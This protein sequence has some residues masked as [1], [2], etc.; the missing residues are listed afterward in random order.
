M[1]CTAKQEAATSC[2]H[3]PVS[4]YPVTASTTYADGTLSVAW[5]PDSAHIA[6]GGADTE[7]HL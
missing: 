3:G 7:V 6:S 5:S 4:S 2:G 1:R